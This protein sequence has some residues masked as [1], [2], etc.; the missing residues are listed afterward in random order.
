MNKISELEKFKNEDKFPELDWS[1]R[2][3]NPSPI[4]IISKMN[5]EVNTF[6][7][8]LSAITTSEEIDTSNRPKLL[9]DW[10]NEWDNF[11]FDTE[12]TEFIVDIMCEAMNIVNIDHQSLLI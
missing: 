5:N 10:F 6:I 11:E 1:D 7:D 3:L 12:E 2:G 9:Q 4:E 8:F